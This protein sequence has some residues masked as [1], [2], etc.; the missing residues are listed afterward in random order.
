M[1]HFLIAAKN[2]IV[3]FQRAK[4]HNNFVITWVKRE[5]GRKNS[6]FRILSSKITIFAAILSTES[7]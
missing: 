1:R 3:K 7:E 2:Y 6:M 5:N 4:I